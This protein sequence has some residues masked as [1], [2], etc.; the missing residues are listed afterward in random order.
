MDKIKLLKIINKKVTKIARNMQEA[1]FTSYYEL[2][3]NP[4]KMFYLNFMLGIAR[5]FGMAVGFTVLSALVIYILQFFVRINLPIIGKFIA[6]IV[7]I[8]EDSRR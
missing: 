8:V 1:N 5:G 7:K 2:I 4:R 6:D 3:Q